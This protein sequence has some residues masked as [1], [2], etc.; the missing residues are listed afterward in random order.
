MKLKTSLLEKFV[1][2]LL[3]AVI[4]LS[5]AVGVL[6]QRVQDL[7]G[8]VI[9]GATA[10]QQAAPAQP[11]QVQV[12]D[13][14]IKGLFSKNLITVGDADKELVLVEVADTSC[15]YCHIASGKN[16]ELNKSVGQQFTLVEDGG[17]Y[18]APVEEMKKLVDAGKAS[19]VYLYTPGHGNGEMG[20][21][22]LLCA[23]EKGK[24][25][26]AHDLLYSSE[27]YD[28]L[29][30]IVKNDKTKSQELADFLKS[31]VSPAEMKACLDS[32][33]YD[34][35]PTDETTI[36]STLGVSGTPAFFINTTRFSGAYSFTDMKSAVDAILN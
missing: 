28:L 33:K 15:P 4:A 30:N 5:F 7:D 11:E 16:P 31:A 26:Q 14:Q 12:T 32:G 9:A 36:S 27:A 24:F 23:H 19:Y 2:V 13:E 6:W 21:K 18:V 25:W 34:S 22:A 35:S 29:N 8:K 1:P 20:H 17:S 10:N 3:V